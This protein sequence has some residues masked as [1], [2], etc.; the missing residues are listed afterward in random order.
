M[1]EFNFRQLEAF[2]VTAE[3]GSFSAA[4]EK[5]FLSQSTVSN[6]IARLE[7][8]LGVVLLE[9]GSRRKVELTKSGKEVYER[10]RDIVKNCEE[11]QKAFVRRSP[12]LTIGASTVPLSY[13]LPAL[14]TAFRQIRPDCRFV[15]KKGN[16][17]E[18]HRLLADNEIELGLVGTVLDK[19]GL[20]YRRLCADR[21]VLVTPN[22]PEYEA[23]KREGASGRELL[24]RPLI[25]R[26]PGSGTQLAVD[27]YLKEAGVTPDSVTVV[28]RI[29]S[30]EAILRS[31]SEGLGNAVLS[32]LSAQRYI[33]D[34]RL[35]CFELERDRSVKRQMYLVYRKE[36]KPSA[37]TQQFIEFAARSC[38]GNFDRIS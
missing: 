18:I 6:H 29:A 22:T 13:I 26:T 21:L 19:K 38:E 34:R 32:A 10:G 30:N 37:V 31:V 1:V 16:S 3:C 24:K 17:S 7:D 33:E 11:L 35:L 8:A 23:L 27:R 20:A 2:V 4:A 15:L 25:V 36:P 28:A 12:E 14:M 5:L 9:R